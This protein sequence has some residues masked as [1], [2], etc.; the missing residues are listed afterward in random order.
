MPPVSRASGGPLNIG[1]AARR[2][3]VPAKTIRFYEGI[4]LVRPTARRANGYRD[5]DA[6]DL[7]ELQFVGRARSLGFSVE[8]CRMLLDLYRDQSRTSAE[9]KGLALA[10]VREI[11]RKIGQLRTMKATLEELIEHCTGDARPDC[12]ILDDLAAGRRM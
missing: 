7:H 12:P 11:D 10:R 3:G 6:R 2:S 1:E 5:Y 4:E 8:Q 9:V